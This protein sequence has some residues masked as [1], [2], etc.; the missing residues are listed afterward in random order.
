MYADRIAMYKVDYLEKVVQCFM[1]NVFVNINTHVSLSVMCYTYWAKP[2]LVY[3]VMGGTKNLHCNQHSIVV[4]CI[5]HL[6]LA[7]HH[8]LSACVLS[9]D[10]L[11]NS[12]K[13]FSAFLSLFPKLHKDTLILHQMTFHLI[14]HLL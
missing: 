13:S 11:K 10:H 9:Y 6:P 7:G 2:F 4:L 5:P 12:I 1:T 8:Y 14:P 3:V